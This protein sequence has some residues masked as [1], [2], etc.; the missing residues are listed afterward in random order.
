M[1]DSGTLSQTDQLAKRSSNALQ[2]KPV[3]IGMPGSG[4]WTKQLLKT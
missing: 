4:G 3:R 1:T 2:E